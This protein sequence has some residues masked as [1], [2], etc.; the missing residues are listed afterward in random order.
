[1][2][3]DKEPGR[4]DVQLF[5][6]IFADLDQVLT[7]LPALAGLGRVPV[8]D[9]GEMV[10]QG[11][12]ASADARGAHTGGFNLIGQPFDFGFDSRL[13]DQRGFGE[14]VPLMGRQGFACLAETQALVVGEFEGEGLD[15]ELG[16]VE[17]R[18][19]TGERL[20]GERQLS[21]QLLECR[22]PLDRGQPG[23]PRRGNQRC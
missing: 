2:A 1:M 8:F 3:M 6:D 4:R 10:R 20:L 17:G 12:T 7:A 23:R 14:Q 5:G 9:A 16:G 22:W 13:V 11:L 18:L 21:A 19:A 15:L